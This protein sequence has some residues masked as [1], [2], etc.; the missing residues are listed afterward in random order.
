MIGDQAKALNVAHTDRILPRSRPELNVAIA[1][2]GSLIAVVLLGSLFARI[3]SEYTQ[4][5]MTGDS[6][7]RITR[8]AFLAMPI[9][10]IDFG[11]QN[12]WPVIA[13]T[14]VTVV[15]TA[16]LAWRLTCALRGSVGAVASLLIAQLV[17]TLLLSGFAVTLNP[18]T[19]AY[20]IYGRL[21]GV[22][23]VN[24][25]VIPPRRKLPFAADTQLTTAMRAWGDPPP[26][27]N[28]G[29]T[30]TL[31][32]AGIGRLTATMSLV[33][34]I[35]G[36]RLLALVSSFAITLGLFRLLAR[37][38]REETVRNVAW[39]A[40]SPLVL[41]ESIVNGHNDVVMVAPALWA[42]VVLDD[43]PLMAA[44][45]IGA[46]VTIKY[47]SIVLLPFILVRVWKLHG[48][49]MA[50][51]AA[52][53]AGAAI[54]LP[55][56]AFWRGPAVLKSVLQHGNVITFSPTALG[57]TLLEHVLHAP[58]I[59]THHPEWSRLVEAVLIAALVAITCAG[60]RRF[61]RN[62]IADPAP[63]WR[64]LVA[65]LA[66]TP[67]IGPYLL[68]W[69]SPMLAARGV[70]GF[71][72]RALSICG[73]SY[74]VALIFPLNFTVGLGFATALIVVPLVA[75]RFYTTR[76]RSLVVASAA[77]AHP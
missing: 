9:P 3:A 29:P 1:W 23:G 25:Y 70:W 58:V 76:N 27:D 54:A 11:M 36:Q 5:G 50:A 59:G 14:L 33:S 49:G 13:V 12:S 38:P 69:L 15:A 17:C 37:K 47:V 2:C 28:Y 44:L 48:A 75:L 60:L 30:W 42:F 55:F 35:I 74:Y 65:L 34:G 68:L 64:T 40:L 19:Y 45:L 52:V 51:A 72:A 6:S 62:G 21:V 77:S 18:D 10:V 4:G 24:P 41:L 71:Y 22:H 57:G 46:S 66:A 8:L 61:A 67:A 63:V 16:Y 53:V 73:L 20:A 32:A 31:L 56:T 7:D 43:A 26:N 39:F